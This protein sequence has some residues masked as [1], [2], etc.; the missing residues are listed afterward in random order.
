MK[1]SLW[2]QVEVETDLRFGTESKAQGARRPLGALGPVGEAHAGLIESFE[3]P[4]NDSPH[5]RS[6]SRDG[7]EVNDPL[8]FP[9]FEHS[10]GLAEFAKIIGD[11]L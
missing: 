2:G 3:D 5:G 11:R 8:V 6:V 4:G 7:H 10:R 1:G 9:K